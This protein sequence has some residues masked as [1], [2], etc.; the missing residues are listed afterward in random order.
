MRGRTHTEMQHTAHRS[1]E[2]SLYDREEG[3][4]ETT[5]A[6][7][8]TADVT[9]T[10]D[11]VEFTEATD[12]IPSTLEFAECAGARDAAPGGVDDGARGGGAVPR[13]R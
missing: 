7:L 2:R 12:A 3:I 11:V 5:G 4:K 6:Y 9:D 8:A 1:Q 13:D 10:R